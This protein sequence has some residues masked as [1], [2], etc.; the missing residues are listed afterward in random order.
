MG[1]EKLRD[2]PKDWQAQFELGLLDWKHTKILRKR[3][4]FSLALGEL[5]PSAGVAWCFFWG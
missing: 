2:F 5:H 1:R 3:A 4:R